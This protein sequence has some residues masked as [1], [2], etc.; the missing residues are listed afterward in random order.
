MIANATG[1]ATLVVELS[2]PARLGDVRDCRGLGRPEL[3]GRPHC[4]L[5]RINVPRGGTA[6]LGAT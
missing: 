4:G 3:S 6:V 2:M 5:H 1:T